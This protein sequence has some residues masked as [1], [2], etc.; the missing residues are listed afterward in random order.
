[1]A[2]P[3]QKADVRPIAFV[4]HNEATG[5]APIVFKLVIRPEELTRSEPSRLTVTQTLGNAWADNFG[6]GVP[7][8]T[9]SGHTG[10]GQ[11]ARPDGLKN[12]IDLHDLIFERWH[13]ERSEAL[14]MGLDP[15]KV[16]LIF[17]DEL[18]TF[19]W[20]VAPRSFVLRRN[21]SRPLLSQFHI[22]LAWLSSNASDAQAAMAAQDATLTQGAVLQG[23]LS[24]LGL[25]SLGNSIDRIT[26]FVANVGSVTTSANQDILG[27]LGTVAKPFMGVVT[28]TQGVL[29]VTQTVIADGT[30]TVS[31]AAGSLVSLAGMVTAAA[32]NTTRTI[33]SIISLPSY[34]QATLAGVATA[35]HNAFCTLVNVF[36]PRD[37]LA[38][39]SDVYG[40]STC[41]STAGGRPISQYA[42]VNTFANLM[43]SDSTPMTITQQAAA[44]LQR[45]TQTDPVVAPMSQGELERHATN[46]AGGVTLQAVAV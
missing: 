32:E 43:R 33:E 11:G 6:P 23:A 14:A 24:D 9:L 30:S 44:S 19:T 21:R 41:S 34:A 46:I 38:D 42:R 40:A 27:A 7:T 2:P 25:S 4:F 13:R 45:M 12:F 16:R 28:L 36:G 10:W 3:S 17:A 8:V 35:F 1:M 5:A 15:D 26:D 18:D 22:E 37:L 29:T 20:V 31:T 39:Y